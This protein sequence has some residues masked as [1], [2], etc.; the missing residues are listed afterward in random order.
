MKRKLEARIR[1]LWQSAAMKR[2]VGFGFVVLLLYFLVL[3][4]FNK[5]LP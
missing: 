5:Q 2:V 3:I 4:L 1:A